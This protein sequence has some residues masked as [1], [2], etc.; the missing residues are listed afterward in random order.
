MSL[1]KSI[2][3]QVLEKIAAK[4]G[5]IA[6]PPTGTPP[7]DDDW[8]LKFSVVELGPLGPENARFQYS[9]GVVPGVE[10]YSD[11]YPLI[12]NDLQVAIEYRATKNKGDEDPQIMAERVLTVLKRLVLQNK[13]WDGLCTD[14]KL[15]NSETDLANYSDRSVVGV[16]F[17]QVQYR[18]STKDP[19]NPDPNF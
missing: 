7:T 5:S 1:D 17:I 11:L 4:I 2:R 18:H 9:A 13:K 12:V 8:P 6:P 15:I 19:R 14:T 10:R 3:Q 16:L